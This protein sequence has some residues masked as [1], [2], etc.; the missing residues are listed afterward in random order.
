MGRPSAYT[1]AVALTVAMRIM[2]GESLAS[3]GRD[4]AMPA[5]STMLAWAADPE[6]PFSE[7]YARACE[8]RGITYGERVAEIGMA[9]AAGKIDPRAGAVAID[10]LKWA[11]ARMARRRFGDKMDPAA[12]VQGGVGVLAIPIAP[13]S[14]A[15]WL[16]LEDGAA[17]SDLAAREA[18]DAGAHAPGGSGP[19]VA[20]AD[21]TLVIERGP[22]RRAPGGGHGVV[23]A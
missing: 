13:G 10:A 11:A 20:A 5:E 19:S 1:E 16:A 21:G 14:M 2:L 17:A 8:G 12:L 3:I 23:R 4:T 22:R 6:H 18:A 9:V 15:E 7:Y